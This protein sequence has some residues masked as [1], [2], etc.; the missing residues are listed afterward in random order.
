MAAKKPERVATGIAGLDEMLAG[1]FLP[2]SAVLLRGAP[3][4]GKSTLALQ[5]LLHGASQ[6]EPGLLIS[7]E[8]FPQSL[9]RDAE[10]LGWN[11]KE[12]EEKELLR[13]HFTSPQV[14]LDSLRSPAS[15]L[16]RLLLEGG[17][18]RV[19]LDSVTHFTRVA[20]DPIE[21]RGVYNTLINALK[22]EQV[23]SLLIGEESRF[24]NQRFEQ[25]KLSYIVDAIV[26]LRYVEIDSAIQRAVIVIKMRGSDHVKDIRRYEIKGKDGL[27]VTGVFEGREGIL[28]GISHRTAV[29]R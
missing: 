1:G 8:E 25:G 4:T 7:F 6:G 27:V 2:G 20:N 16:S 9:H 18:R 24:E 29:T 3:G 22:R 10:S 15:A 19:V 12:V 13:L 11:L 14:L 23:T 21:L 28:S 5:Y 17:I 26:L